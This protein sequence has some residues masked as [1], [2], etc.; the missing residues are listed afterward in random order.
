MSLYLSLLIFSIQDVG[1]YHS[2]QPLFFFSFFRI[3]FLFWVWLHRI[4]LDLLYKLISGRIGVSNTI[5]FRIRHIPKSWKLVFSN[6]TFSRGAETKNSISHYFMAQSTWN[7]QCLLLISCSSGVAI[8]FLY[9][10]L[11]F[12]WKIFC[13][14]TITNFRKISTR[15]FEDPIFF[16]PK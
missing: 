11:F 13:S 12:F 15:K 5:F 9:L 3:C 10:C 8:C 6:F 2:N 7:L 4:Y 14:P 1:H 16:C